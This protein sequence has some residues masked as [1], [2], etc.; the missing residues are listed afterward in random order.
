MALLREGLWGLS[1]FAVDEDLQGRG[2]GRRLLDAAL[3]HGDG[4]RGWIV[5]STERPAAMRRYARAGLDLHPA[6]AAAGLVDARGSPSA[7]ARVED[8]GAGGLAVAD[9]IGRAARGA[10]HARDLP[11]SLRH[12]ARLLVL[13]DRAF[14]LLGRAGAVALLGARDEDAAQTA[15]VGRLARTRRGGR[16]C[17]STSSPRASDWAVPV[18]LD[19]GLLLSPDGP[20]FLRGDVGPLRALRPERRVALTVARAPSGAGRRYSNLS[21]RSLAQRGSGAASWRCSGPASLRSAPHSGHSPRS[22]RGRGP[23][24]A[25]PSASASCAHAARSSSS[26]ADVRARELVAAAGLV[27]LAGVDLDDG[28]RPAPGSACTARVGAAAKRRRRL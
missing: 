14:A 16:R 13:E 1:L 23:G 18:L 17:R 12:G 22:P 15:A 7:A 20:V 24:R 8:A 26:R 5:L 10:G 21:S 25:A 11:S 2:V 28:R 9:A 4:A 6:V 27:D 19:A 3:R